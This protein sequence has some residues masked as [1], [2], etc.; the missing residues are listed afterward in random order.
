[1]P[2]VT[3]QDKS[4]SL[5]KQ[6][7]RDLNLDSRLSQVARPGRQNTLFVT[8]LTLRIPYTPYYI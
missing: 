2:V 5:A 8:K 4:F 1:M 3:L 7:A 6:L